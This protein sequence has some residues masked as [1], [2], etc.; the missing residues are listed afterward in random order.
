MNKSMLKKSISMALTGCL[1]A[2]PLSFGAVPAA[3]AEASAGSVIGAIIGGVAASSSLHKQIRYYNDTEEGQEEFFNEMKKEYGVNEDYALNAR[4]DTIMSN[5]S[6]SIAQV[7]PSIEEHPYRYFIN[8]DESFNAFCTLGH[9]M[10]VN[11]GLFS[12]ITNDDEIAVVLGHEMGHGQKDHPAKGAK[13]SIAPAVLASA[14]GSFAGVLVAN[15]WKNQGI[16]KPMEWEADNLAFDYITHSNYNPG[17]CAGIWQHV[18]DKSGDNSYYNFLMVGGSDHPSNSSRRDNYMK[19]LTE[20]SGNHVTVTDE[21]M[22]QVNKKDFLQPAAIGDMSTRERA[23]FVAGNLSAAYHN[24][25]NTSDVTTDGNIVK[26][27]AQPIIECQGDDMS[28]SEA[29]ARLQAIK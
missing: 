21:G 17:A 22:V 12:A 6:A 3:T 28:A 20:Y 14:T 15:L 1:L 4:L 16:T 24:K 29:A 8:K 26:M 19:K 7:D 13:R 10:S 9:N 25:H 23:Y 5:L 11:T 27:G 18:I 2:L